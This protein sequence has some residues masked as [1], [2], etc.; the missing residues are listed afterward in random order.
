MANQIL[1]QFR[2][3]GSGVGRL[4]WGQRGVWRSIQRRGGSEFVGGIVKLPDV[5]TVAAMADTLGYIMARHQSL[6]TRLTFDADGEVLQRVYESGEVVLDIVDAAGRDP[7]EVAKA[8]RA[9]Y[10]SRDFDYTDEWPVRMAAVCQG[11]IVIYMV[12]VYNHLAV[13]AHSLLA[14]LDDLMSR[15]PVTGVAAGPVTAVQPLE[16]AR[17][18]QKKS[19]QRLTDGALR[20]WGRVLRSVTPQRFDESVDERAPRFWDLAYESRAAELAMRAIAARIGTDTS[21]VL[22]AAYAVAL[23]RTA[24]RNPVVLQLAVSNRFRPGF[25]GAVTPLAQ[26]APCMIDVAGITFDEAIGRAWHAAMTTY[27]NSYYDPIQRVALVESINAERGEEIDIQ[28]YFNDRR[29][30]AKPQPAGPPPTMAEIEAALPASKLTWGPC[31]DFPQPKFYLD[32]NDIPN[33]DGMELSLTADTRYVSPPDMERFVRT[34]ESIVVQAA[35]DTTMIT[36]VHAARE[37]V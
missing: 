11:D 22:L 29:D 16:L 13:D 4:T 15:D 28:C 32:V 36:G 9:E 10:E 37:T 21:P 3:E 26:S 2:G 34:V 6:R 27:L 19:A 24:G 14:L 23:A 12:V 33:S 35:A 17:Q 7:S 18:Q 1:V 25:A 8:A 31:S 5:T 30:Q 20:H